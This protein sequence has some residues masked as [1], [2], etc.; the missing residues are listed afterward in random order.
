AVHERDAADDERRAGDRAEIDDLAQHE[1]PE[2]DPDHGEHVRDRGGARGA[3]AA[4]EPE[5][6]QVRQTR[7]QY[8][9]PDDRAGPDEAWT[10]RPRMLRSEEHTSELQSLAYLV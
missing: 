2:R 5:E 4:Q 8:A 3:P 1:G 7:S 6:G 10:Q 9:E